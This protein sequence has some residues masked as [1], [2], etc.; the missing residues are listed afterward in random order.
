MADIPTHNGHNQGRNGHNHGHAAAESGHA[1][2]DTTAAGHGAGEYYLEQLLTVL[3]CA[4]IGTIAVVMYVSQVDS[5]TGLKPKLGLLLTPGFHPW[6][7]AGGV[8]LLVLT[9]IRMASLWVQSGTAGGV[10]PGHVH[11]PD[12]DHGHD[13]AHG[14]DAHAGHDHGAG[15]L[16]LKV[17]PFAF[18]VLLCVMGWPNATLSNDAID[19]RLGKIDAIGAVAGVESADKT[20]IGFDFNEL[21][22]AAYDPGKRAEFAG[23]RIR[24]KGQ[25][26]RVS[27]K[28]YQLF[29]LKM[30]C[31]VADTIPLKARIRSDVVIPQSQFNDY[32]WVTVEG[33]LQFVELP[34]KRQFLPVIGIGNGGLAKAAAE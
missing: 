7:L 18:P 15:G 16:Y 26:K 22:A 11:G 34:E 19:S 25:L 23:R 4:A 28:D 1:G 32:D 27:E 8:V 5:P 3:V 30:T 29:K 12:C 9:A 2:G 31:C 20:V 24:V 6:V 14:G 10:E 21:N 33:V 13:H 17:I